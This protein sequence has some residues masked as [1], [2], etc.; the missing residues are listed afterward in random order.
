MNIIFVCCLRNNTVWWCSAFKKIFVYPVYI[1]SL[2]ELE[3]RNPAYYKIY[4]KG[5]FA[6]LDKLVFPTYKVKL[7]SKEETENCLFWVGMDFGLV[8]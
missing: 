3:K 2:E 4:V 8:A 7:I 1:E 6:T 5:E